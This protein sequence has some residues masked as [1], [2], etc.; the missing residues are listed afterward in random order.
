MKEITLSS[1]QKSQIES[2][3]A[4]LMDK[5]WSLDHPVFLLN[6]SWLKFEE[7]RLEQ[8]TERLPPDNSREA[9]ELVRYYELING[10][11]DYL[12]AIQKCWDEFGI[13]EFHNALRN[14]WYW[15][16]IGNH[17]WTFKRL[18]QL[19][20]DYKKFALESSPSIPLIILS[21]EDTTE[22]HLILWLSFDSIMHTSKS[23]SIVA[24]NSFEII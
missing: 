10:G 2:A 1:K 21:R 11:T 23:I 17:G 4:K 14:Y 12:L 16:D 9:P 24:D 19:I 8:L 3:L 13:E 22:E 15:K 18:I 20:S 7:L 6:R 5:S